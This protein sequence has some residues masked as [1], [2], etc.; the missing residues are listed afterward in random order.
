MSNTE[1]YAKLFVGGDLSGIQKFLYNITSK[2]AAVSLKGRSFYL[3]EYMEGV[4]DS[5][6]RLPA[7]AEGSPEVIYCSGGKFYIIVRNTPEIQETLTEY[8]RKVK[9]EI[10]KEH[11]GQLSI[12]LSWVPFSENADKSINANGQTNQTLGFLWQC[13]TEDFARQKNQKFLEEIK[14]NHEDFFEV[15]PVGGKPKVCAVTGIESDELVKFNY[16]DDRRDEDSIYVLHSVRAQIQL[17]EAL[18]EKEQTHT[19][20]EYAEDTYLGILRMDVDGL[21]KRFADGFP[22]IDEYKDFSNYLDTYFTQRDEKE[23][24]LHELQQKPAFR[25]YTNIL[26]AGGD[27]IFVVG[28]WD[29]VI[30]LAAEV[31]RDFVG[32]ISKKCQGISLSGGVAIVHPKFPIAKAAEMAGEA[33]DA[34]KAYVYKDKDGNEYP[35]D[36]FCMFGQAV[37][38]KYEFD[39]VR[40]YMTD[41]YN[42]IHD[43]GMPRAILHKL[44]TYA[45]MEAKT[46]AAKKSGEQEDYSYIWHSAY[47]LTR[48]MERQ[49]N[50]PP[51][52]EFCRHLRDCEINGAKGNYRLLAVAARWA[53]L[54]LRMNN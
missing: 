4:C 35:K 9:A 45:I 19:F 34:A 12:N 51:V 39:Y 23:S 36:A 32:Y 10:W 3:R 30:D 1:N 20:E 8:S 6:V 33:E 24:R 26:Y 48:L 44:M 42:L 29:K 50:N 14:E 16:K 11:Q 2:K 41:L 52:V 25:E 49:G 53:E 46:A 17:G 7:V 15:I 21:G 40:R 38:W 13:I 43:E 47:Y 27:D 5:I 37:S 54:K 22:S 31:R 18:R 28:R